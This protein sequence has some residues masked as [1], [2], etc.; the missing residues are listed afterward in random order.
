VEQEQRKPNAEEQKPQEQGRTGGGPP[1]T[2]DAN[3]KID[4]ALGKVQVIHGIYDAKFEIAGK[5]VAYAREQLDAMYN[6]PPGAQALLNG[7][8]VGEGT[9]LPA[10]STLEFI[11]QAGTK[12]K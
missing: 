2:S 12:G 8:P 3:A 6:L 10:D 7:D 4:K 11:K 1:D 5:T 9:I